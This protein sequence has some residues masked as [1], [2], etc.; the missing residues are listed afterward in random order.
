MRNILIIFCSLFPLSGLFANPQNP[1]KKPNIVWIVCEDM[2]PHL[3]SYGEKV[4]KTPVLDQL[5][6]EAVRYTQVYSTAGVC[7]PSRCA[8]ITGNYQTAIGG[9][10]MRTLGLSANAL[11]DYPKGLKP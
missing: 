2:S 10:N 3:G 4:A 11:D 8:L 5:A 9:H 6:K 1:V 7:A